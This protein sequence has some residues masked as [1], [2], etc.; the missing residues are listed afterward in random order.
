MQNELPQSLI[1]AVRYFSD[2]KICGDYMRKVKW[3]DGRIACPKCA[4]ENIGEIATRNL[5]KCRECGKQ[6]SMKVGTIFEDSPLGLDKWFVAVWCIANAKNGISSHE[7]GRA[8]NVGQKTAWFM[9]HR[10]RE[11]MRTGT[12]RKLSGTV[13]SDESFVGAEARNMHER[14]R[15]QRI[16][17]RGAVGKRIVHGMLERG[18][19]A[20]ASEVRANVVADADAITLA[21]AVRHN[22]ET[23]PNVYTDSATAYS[24]LWLRF[25]HEAVDHAM[26]YV[27]GEVHTNGLENFWSLFKRTVKG[28]Y[29]SVA[30]FHLRRYVDEQVFRFNQRKTDD[31]SRFA[32][33][34]AGVPGKRLTWRELCGVDG[35]GFMGLQ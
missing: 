18:T 22:V 25:Q 15:E 32:Q 7:L 2:L 14:K 8:L 29:V 26:E 31:A 35:A 16:K 27:R 12:F 13:E 9:L 34:L 23:G 3:P 24:D 21:G 33:V 20:K 28:T 30:P 10:I 4:G 11:A 5:L 1:E 6:F 17:G 19:D